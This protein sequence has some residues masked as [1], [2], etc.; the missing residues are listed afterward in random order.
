RIHLALEDLLG[1]LDRQQGDVIAQRI[2]RA[3]GFLRGILLGLRQDA[4]TLGL[5]LATG[6]IDQR[7]SLLLGFG[8]AGMGFGLCRS[9]DQTDARL[10]LRQ[11]GLALL[12]GG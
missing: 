4:R 8:H 2:A 7:R 10:R 9:F 6:L 11:V 1:A 5:G 12:G 3:L